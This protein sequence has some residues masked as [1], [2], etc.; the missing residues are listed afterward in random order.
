MPVTRRSGGKG[1]SAPPPKLGLRAKGKRGADPGSPPTAKRSKTAE[2]DK[3]QKII[4]ETMDVD[5][6]EVTKDKTAQV[7][8]REGQNSKRNDEEM[9]DQG[10]VKEGEKS[11]SDEV[12]A[13]ESEV[14][15]AAKDEEA[16]KDEKSTSNNNTVV[17]DLERKA[18]MP[19]SI[20]EKGIIYFFFRGRVNVEEP[21]SVDDISRSYIVLRPLPLGA[22]LGEGP[23]EDASNA[24][25][26][27]LPKK[28]LPKSKQDRFIVFVEKANASIKDLKDQFI[29]GSDYSTKTSGSV[30]LSQIKR[31]DSCLQ[32]RTQNKAYS[33]RN[34]N[35]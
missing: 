29:S 31:S 4:E 33:S 24:R 26:L 21:Q 6:G 10:K 32:Y 28:F 19:S 15:E 30:L 12:K 2:N 11:A 20:L 7:D 23:L 34:P 5:S 1:S 3:E 22:K 25:R 35:C 13:D 16:E 8:D 27:V 17:Q 14:K 18:A 9:A